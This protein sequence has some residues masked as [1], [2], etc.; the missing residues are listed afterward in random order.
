MGM[1]IKWTLRLLRKE[2]LKYKTINEFRR[3]SRN[4]YFSAYRRNLLAQ[5][6]GHMP[7]PQRQSYTDRELQIEALKYGART[8]FANGNCGAY[9]SAKRRGKPFLDRIC[10]H[11][12]PSKNDPWT[13][14]DIELEAKKYLKRKEFEKNSAAAYQ[15]AWKKGQEFLDSICSH[16]EKAGNSSM[17]EKEILD[18]VSSI[19]INATKLIDRKV[20]IEGKSHIKG[21]H[22]DIFVPELNRGIEFDGTYFH[23]FDGL[24]RSKPNWPDDDIRNYPRLKDAWFASKGIQILHI[25]EEDW[26]KDKE[27]CLNRCLKFLGIGT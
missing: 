3:G 2:A 9:C 21:F 13:G 26:K 19:W 17:A 7:S 20:K 14:E 15:A 24:K 18:L 25:K 11:M 8:D 1:R 10:L 12:G 4:A 6:C 22:I 23:S 5:I 16:M 27:R